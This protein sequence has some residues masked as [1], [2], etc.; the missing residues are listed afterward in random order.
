MN[1]MKDK[2]IGI[3]AFTILLVILLASSIMAF[4]VAI[5]YWDRP[6]WYPLK[7]APGESKIVQLTLQNT[8]SENMTFKATITSDIATLDD[9]S[10]EY[11]VPS[12]EIDKI[13]NVKVEVPEDA[14]I[15]TIYKVIASFQQISLG[16][17]GMI[18]MAGAFTINFPVEV[19]GE[20]ESEQ[21]GQPEGLSIFWIIS[22]ILVL[23]VMVLAL[24]IRRRRKSKK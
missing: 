23:A 3:F 22:I 9:K 21:Y 15:G 4:A 19:V 17:G 13:V 14:E 1:K 11:F 10:D 24:S 8:G 20:E 2:K 7:L 16:E 6:E 12:G 5:P 18:R